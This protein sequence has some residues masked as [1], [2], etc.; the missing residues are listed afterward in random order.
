M[1]PDAAVRGAP[2]GQRAPGGSSGVPRPQLGLGFLW[3]GRPTALMAECGQPA[4]RMGLVTEVGGHVV[5]FP[6]KGDIPE[7]HKW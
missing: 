3:G 2:R 5:V 1:P 6:E 4:L 7:L